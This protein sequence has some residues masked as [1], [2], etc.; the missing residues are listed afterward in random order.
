MRDCIGLF[1]II[2]LIRKLTHDFL[3]RIESSVSFLLCHIFRNKI[4]VSA[5]LLFKEFTDLI[6]RHIQMVPETI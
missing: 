5:S 1:V 2:L 6:G 3:S 4:N